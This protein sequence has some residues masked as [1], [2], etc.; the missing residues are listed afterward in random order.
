MKPTCTDS[1]VAAAATTTASPAA[2]TATTAT[3]ATAAP[4][5]PAAPAPP[6]ARAGLAAPAPPAPAPAAATETAPAASVLTY[7]TAHG[8]NRAQSCQGADFSHPS[9]SESGPPAQGKQEPLISHQAPL[10]GSLNGIHK[11]IRALEQLY[12]VCLGGLTTQK[13]AP[14]RVPVKVLC[15]GYDLESVS[16]SNSKRRAPGD[17]FLKYN[18]FWVTLREYYY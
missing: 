12:R 9:P 14:L 8:L 11:A 3:T 18:G 15:K 17:L 13:K 5:A 6:A 16:V 4:A 2:G 1:L 7:K 10:K